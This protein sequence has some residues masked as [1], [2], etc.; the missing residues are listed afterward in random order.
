MVSIKKFINSIPGQF[1]IGGITLA[2]IYF[3][4]NNVNNTA[5]AAVVAGV[6]IG[7]PSTIFVDNSK[8]SSYSTNLLFQ[9]FLLLLVTFEFWF[10]FH[11]LNYNKFKGVGIAMLTWLILSCLYVFFKSM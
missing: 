8:V 6:P 2:G 10:L 9:T 5:I 1:L 3:F 4:S 7:L 11:K